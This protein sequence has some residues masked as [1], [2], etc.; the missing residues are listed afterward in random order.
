MADGRV[1]RVFIVDDHPVVASGLRSLLSNAPDLT[2]VGQAE[3]GESALA[4]IA[5]LQ[6]DLAI[7]DGSLPGMSG[8]EL[9][10]RLLDRF[11][12]LPTI[13]LTRHNEGA[14]VRAFFRA[15]ARG[16]VSKDSAADDLLLAIRT[17]L[18]GG[19]HA[20]PALASQIRPVDLKAPS[21]GRI[22]SDREAHVLR[23]IAEGYGNKE[24]AARLDLSPKSV[25][26]YRA[27]AFQKTGLRSRSDVVRLAWA[28]GW[29]SERQE[30]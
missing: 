29:F 1:H 7:V 11:P 30:P 8:V 5:R 26:T 9:V 21:T 19:F 4:Q 17:V 6:P 18:A 2:V 3:D 22:L 14:Y 25:E 23:L 16:Y 10:R 13:A 24:I 12:R 15:G 27:R 28:E 20:D